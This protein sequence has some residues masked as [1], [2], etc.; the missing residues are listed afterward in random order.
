MD[1]MG[2]TSSQR[3]FIGDGGSN[4]LQGARNLNIAA[5]MLNDQPTDQRTVLRVDIHEWDGP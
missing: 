2:V 3:L 5:Y 1:G 4:E